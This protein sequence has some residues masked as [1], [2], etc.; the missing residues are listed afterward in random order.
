MLVDGLVC[1]I[2]G[3]SSDFSSVEKV[4]EFNFILVNRLNDGF[5]WHYL[6]RSYQSLTRRQICFIFKGLSMKVACLLGLLAMF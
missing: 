5:Q 3:R 1:L 6:Q 4:L 2:S